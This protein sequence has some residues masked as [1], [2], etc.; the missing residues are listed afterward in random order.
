MDK[1]IILLKTDVLPYEV[2]IIF[3]NYGLYDYLNKLSN[4]EYKELLKEIKGRQKVVTK[5]LNFYSYKNK[6]SRRLLS[7]MHPLAQLDA[8]YFLTEYKGD[9]LK[10]FSLNKCFSIRIPKKINKR[11]FKYSSVEEYANG[12]ID[13][14][15]EEKNSKN[16]IYEKF[17]YTGRYR[18]LVEFH[19]SSFFKKMEKKYQLLQRIDIKKCFYNIY[20][21]SI[22]WAYLGDKEVAKS[23]IGEKD[24]ISAI[25]DKIIQNSNYG[26]TNGILVGSEFSRT[27]AEIV[28]SKIDSII[29]IKLKNKNIILGRDY[30]IARYVDDIYIFC[31]SSEILKEIYNEYEI[32]LEVY[33]LSISESKAV[34]EERPFLKETLWSFQV[35]NLVKNFFENFSDNKRFIGKNNDEYYVKTRKMDS[36]FENVI[37]EIKYLLNLYPKEDYK[38][39]SY[40]FSS[41][42]IE[43]IKKN[44]DEL[45]NKEENSIDYEEIVESFIVRLI[46]EVVELLTY[47]VTFSFINNN[48]YKYCIILKEIRS[49]C[50]TISKRN[51]K[52]VEKVIFS[53]GVELI[54]FNINK[55]NEVLILICF[56][57]Y[58]NLNIPERVF[59]LFFE[60]EINYFQ[61]MSILFYLNTDSRKK[62]GYLTTLKKIN[63]YLSEKA[64]VLKKDYE[65]E[66]KKLICSENIYLLHELA[67]CTEFL[68]VKS[69][70]EGIKKMK[71]LMEEIKD[72]DLLY[73]KIYNSNFSYINWNL[74]EKNFMKE[75]IKKSQTKIL[76]Y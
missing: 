60:E 55:K 38:I 9:L 44:L 66:E 72:K 54:E 26:E 52:L 11:E 48:L 42:K 57:K 24:R 46:I 71:G 37:T 62:R 1:N 13:T 14:Q 43:R 20:T 10:Y 40:F 17:F 15:T 33:K 32:N 74:E 12:I 58:F 59:N 8:L 69:L 35:K 27:A 47:I 73:S 19:G 68:E 22:D 6:T 64:R 25:L 61:I 67:L 21:H 70:E 53:K 29:F 56:L 18:S 28:L 49:I 75:V 50:N 23:L 30:N 7:L 65:S 45:K 39:I 63:S 34:L 5:P 41:F 51:K 2:P 76:E 36:C 16:H 3:S 4:D 31:N